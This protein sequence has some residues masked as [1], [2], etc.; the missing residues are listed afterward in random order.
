[1]LADLLDKNY[2]G[3]NFPVRHSFPTAWIPMTFLDLK[4]FQGRANSN[5]FLHVHK[6]VPILKQLALKLEILL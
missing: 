5:F 1:M 6:I 2:I 3:S 4:C